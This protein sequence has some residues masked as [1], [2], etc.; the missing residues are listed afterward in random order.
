MKRKKDNFKNF[1]QR[2]QYSHPKNV[3]K[4]GHNVHN[5]HKNVHNGHGLWF[6]TIGMVITSFLIQY[7]FM[8]YVMVHDPSKNFRNSLGKAYLSLFMA[9]TMGLVE[10]V[11][12]MV[13]QYGFH[14][15][16][17]KWGWV[18]TF[19]IL[20]LISLVIYRRQWGI[21]DKEYLKEMVE[22]HSM[23]ILTS[24]EILKTSTNP[25]VQKLASTILSTQ[26]KEIQ[27]MNELVKKI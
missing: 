10:V 9:F 21:R 15:G 14:F 1:I 2:Q 25:E 5:V 19:M 4:N 23:A 27:S 3:D 24:E 6:M 13:Q 17:W 8:S 11:L 26:Q 12:H 18:I 22:H 7:Y 16:E 20:T